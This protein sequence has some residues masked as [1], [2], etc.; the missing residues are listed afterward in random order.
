MRK[1]FLIVSITA[2]LAHLF[3]MPVIAA[4]KDGVSAEIKTGK[5]EYTSNEAIDCIIQVKNSN[6]YEIKNLTITAENPKSYTSADGYALQMSK[7]SLVP[8]ETAEL[9]I[10]FVPDQNAAA[11]SASK[12]PGTGVSGSTGIWIG[13]ILM[14]ISAAL[15]ILIKRGRK[16]RTN[17]L[18]LFLLCSS[19]ATLILSK[20][21]LAED[22][23]KSLSC[24]DTV[25][26]SGQQLSLNASVSYFCSDT[27]SE[28]ID[29]ALNQDE[30]TYDQS[31]DVY[32][33]TDDSP[34]TLTGTISGDTTRVSKLSFEI[35]N[36]HGSILQN[37]DLTPGDSF[38]IENPGFVPGVNLLKLTAVLDDGSTNSRSF[39]LFNNGT[40]Y[41][42][43]VTID[44]N[45]DDKDGLINYYEDYY[46]TDKAK[47][48]TDGDGLNDLIELTESETDPLHEYTDNSDLRDPDRD[49]DEDGLTNIEEINAGTGIAQEDSDFDGLKDGEEVKNYSTDPLN[50]DTDGDGAEDGW[51]V[52]N[53]YDPLTADQNF[54]STVVYTNE[55]GNG[56]RVTAQL[57]GNQLDSFRIEQSADP[58]IDDSK[59][60]QL[61]DVLEISTEGQPKSAQLSIDFDAD[62]LN[63]PAVVPVICYIN[64]DTQMLEPLATTISGNTAVAELEH[65]S[66]YVL[67]NQAD[68]DQFWDES[69]KKP[70][71]SV[72]QGV[73]I[74]FV[75]DQS[76]SMSWN[77]PNGMRLSLTNEFI[78]KLDSEK[79][80]AG[81][82]L[83]SNY[84][85]IRAELTNDKTKLNQAVQNIGN[86]GGTDG[87]LGLNAGIR[88]LISDNSSSQKSI[89]F[90]TD[91]E[92][93]QTS[94]S[95][96]T[97]IQTAK[98]NNIKIYTIGLGSVD[99]QQLQDIADDTGGSFY[100]T[101]QVSGLI[102]SFSKAESETIDFATD[103]NNDG[104][105][106]YYTKL[107][108]SGTLRTGKG[109]QL[110]KGISYEDVQ[111]N[112]DYD[113][114]GLR[115]GDEINVVNFNNHVYVQ[116]FSDP[117]KSDTDYDGYRDYDD[118]NPMEWD[119]SDRDLAI[120]STLTYADPANIDG[121]NK[122]YKSSTLGTDQDTFFQD[123]ADLDGTDIG[124]SKCWKVVDQKLAANYHAT[125]FKNGKNIVIA[126]CGS[127]DM[128]DW[129]NDFNG[130]GILGLTYQQGLA[131]YDAIKTANTY[132]NGYK[133]Y[134]TG[135]SLGGYLAQCGTYRILQNTNITP[136]KLVYFNGNGSGHL[137]LFFLTQ[138]VIQE[139]L[140]DYYQQTKAV[141]AYRVKGDPVSALGHTSWNVE[142]ISK[143]K[144][145]E[146]YTDK[147][148]LPDINKYHAMG[149]FLHYLSAGTR[150]RIDDLNKYGVSSS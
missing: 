98:D 129:V 47:A 139:K 136:E 81:I 41:E 77:D 71:D 141:T 50:A 120:F 86:T 85:D 27:T 19:I 29:F 68:V 52:A 108:C 37:G 109:E 102:D 97:L 84:L 118:D 134:V 149:N 48:D 30:Y 64:P 131:E 126:Y 56:A 90:M 114:D 100:Y 43:F 70:A 111:G 76:G 95:Y 123:G 91:G 10:S 45:D 121:K 3:C 42:Q 112:S 145:I 32:H 26:V 94:Y 115:N 53:G 74:A 148:A 106:D 6:D 75:L 104:I 69:I 140:K 24:S 127:N 99:R 143:W 28:A 93:T 96:E 57:D 72:N 88:Q 11:V 122:M 36:D 73:S 5:T 113:G 144:Y 142:V 80:K 4:D 130:Y 44:Q 46:G 34:T 78:Q 51:E 40:Q 107:I 147:K 7:D 87:S 58:V 8:G 49:R 65:F 101:D 125:I 124:I 79:D 17:M 25:A 89:I 105:S 110:F 33:L 35:S 55:S 39:T 18:V 137:S 132:C 62:L 133:I 38:S 117:V 15:I 63:D 138:I 9:K 61:S 31:S 16:T 150:I 146:H 128:F 92:D 13:L 67:M 66:E 1:W 60:G 2:V 14:A 135:H 23:Q 20:P 54:E 21:A 103:S 116:T 22:L 83:F 59:P 119:V 82:I 12:M